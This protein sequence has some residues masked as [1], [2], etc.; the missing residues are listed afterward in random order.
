MDPSA[1]V[2]EYKCPCCDAGLVF[3][4]ESQNMACPYCDNTFEVDTVKA[5]NDQRNHADSSTMD[6]DDNQGRHMSVDEEAQLH[7][8]Q[9]PTCSGS[10]ISDQQTI[11]TFCPYCGNPTILPGRIGGILRPDGVIPFKTSKDDATQT[12]LNLCKGKLLLPKFFTSQQQ[13]EK[14]IGMYVPFWLYDCSGD[15]TGNYK[16]TRIRTWSDRNY[17]YTKTDHFMLTRA[18]G[19]S[20]SGIPMDASSKMEDSFMESLEPFDYTQ[21]ADFNTAYLSGFFADKYDVEA[22]AGEARIRQRVD[23]SMNDLIQSSLMGYHSVVPTSRQ[24]AVKQGKAKYVLLPVWL[25]NTRYKDQVYTFA[26]NGQTGKITGSFPICPKRTAAWFS[27][28]A[29]G[30]AAAA[31]L[32][33]TF[34]L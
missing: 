25:L 12:F 7:S 24:L 2:M 22:S 16:A 33:M 9:C 27:G 30:V 6:W 13:I 11:S 14:I 17:H 21:M 15:F 29:A 10:L 31:F 5:Y 19:A 34:I 8:F 1:N 26:M 32:L 23:N 20:F 3:S 28:I 18:A 4:E